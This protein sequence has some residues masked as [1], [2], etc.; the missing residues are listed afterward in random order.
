MTPVDSISTK[1]EPLL[2]RSLL[3]ALVTAVIHIAVLQGYVSVESVDEATVAGAVD[4]LGALVAAF[5]SRQA[6]TPVS[7]PVLQTTITTPVKVHQPT[8]DDRPIT[9]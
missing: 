5:W 6:V 1:R 7:D 9:V 8:L 2:Y 4:I 3:T